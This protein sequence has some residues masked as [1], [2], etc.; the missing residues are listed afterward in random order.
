MVGLLSRDQWVY[1][2]CISIA[3]SLFPLCSPGLPHCHKRICGP[4]PAKAI[5]IGHNSR[6][7]DL[8]HTEVEWRS[9]LQVTW[10]LARGV[11]KQGWA[12]A[13]FIM[14][15][16]LQQ[17][18][19]GGFQVGG[20][21]GSRQLAED[22]SHPLPAQV[23]LVFRLQGIPQ[24]DVPVE[25]AWK[26]FSSVIACLSALAWG[27][28]G[29]SCPPRRTSLHTLLQSHLCVAGYNAHNR[30]S[31]VESHVSPSPPPFPSHIPLPNRLY[32]IV[33]LFLTVFSVRHFGSSRR[34]SCNVQ[35]M[36]VGQTG[37][38]C[39][40]LVGSAGDSLLVKSC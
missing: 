15:L 6:R 26:T 14:L 37:D 23:L 5:L 39:S 31:A 36:S 3:F 40:T 13:H 24:V 7:P 8:D 35:K 11:G 2:C 32:R 21:A 30:S 22:M 28:Q 27:L 33:S 38:G 18:V 19:D 9:N 20:P 12:P 17:G 34:V 16:L 25:L 1:E 10:N 4:L 29:L